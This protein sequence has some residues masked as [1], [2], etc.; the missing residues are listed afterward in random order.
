MGCWVVGLLGCW[1]VGLLGCWVVGLL[2]CWVVGLLGCWVVIAAR[3]FSAGIRLNQINCVFAEFIAIAIEIPDEI[4]VVFQCRL[5]VAV[6]SL[7]IG[8]FDAINRALIAKR[9]A[10]PRQQSQC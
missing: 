2:G 6:K 4:A 9:I 3:L 10:T 5:F 7:T 1:V 8:C